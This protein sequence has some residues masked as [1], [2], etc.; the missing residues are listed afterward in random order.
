MEPGAER[1]RSEELGELRGVLL[2]ERVKARDDGVLVVLS[3]LCFGNSFEEAILR[4]AAVD[5]PP[6]RVV[7]IGM[8]IDL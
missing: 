3:H 7:E 1:S 2:R 4:G 5:P 8:Q 6:G